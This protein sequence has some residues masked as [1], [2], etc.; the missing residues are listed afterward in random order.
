LNDPIFTFENP[1]TYSITQTV[2]YAGCFSD[3]TLD[4]VVVA[5]N[6]V[7]IQT[8]IIQCDEEPIALDVTQS[9]PADYLWLVDSSIAS[10]LEVSSEGVFS[11]EI[12]D[13]HC[14]QQ[15]DINVENFNYDLIAVDLPLDSSICAQRPIEL[16]PEIDL[17]ATFAWSDG[18]EQLQRNISE[19]GLYTL[20]TSL[21]GC[22][23][24]SSIQVLAEDCST[25]LY[26]PNAFSPNLDGIND[27]FYPLGDNFEVLSFQVFDRWGALVHDDPMQ[28]WDGRFR[29][30]LMSPGVF[31]YTLKINNNLLDEVEFYKGQVMLVK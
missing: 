11:V 21:D 17:Q 23:I 5:P 7:D 12:S 25:Q 2:E 1:G 30:G 16:K 8:D 15:F 26:L 13:R 9:Y 19:S 31:S 14:T 3:Y 22:S 29:G 6:P 4:I 18:A 27:D 20:T 10:V 24:S 28:E